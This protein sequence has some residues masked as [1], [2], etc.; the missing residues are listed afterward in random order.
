MRLKIY[1]D[2]KLVADYPEIAAA[3]LENQIKLIKNHLLEEFKE[4]VIRWEK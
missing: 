3:T 1:L 4:V 2:N